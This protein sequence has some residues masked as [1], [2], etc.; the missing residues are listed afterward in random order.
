MKAPKTVKF[1]HYLEN[2]VQ[3]RIYLV[4][5]SNIFSLLIHLMNKKLKT[6]TPLF[7]LKALRIGPPVPLVSHTDTDLHKV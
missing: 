5:Y 3:N 7:C 2:N 6:L 4:K 1:Q